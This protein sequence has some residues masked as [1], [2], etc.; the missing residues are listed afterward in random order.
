MDVPPFTTSSLESSATTC[1]TSY[2]SYHSQDP[3]TYADYYRYRG[4][5]TT[6]QYSSLTSPYYP[7]PYGDPHYHHHF[8]SPY[9]ML[10]MQTQQKELVKPPYSYIALI[11]MAIQSSAEKKLTLSGIY[12]FIMDK[13]P[14][15]RQNKQGWQNSIRHN[16]S[17]N[18]CFLKVPRDDN[19][20]GK[21]SYWS[22]DPDSMNMFENGSYLRRRR[23]FRKKENK[24]EM[25]GVDDRHPSGSEDGEHQG[26]NGSIM[27]SEDVSHGITNEN[28]PHSN[29]D[30]TISHGIRS[31]EAQ[32]DAREKENNSPKEQF[33]NSPKHEEFLEKNT[34]EN[35]TK[36][37]TPNMNKQVTTESIKN[38]DTNGETESHTSSEVKEGK[39]EN[40]YEA[41]SSENFTTVSS[42]ETIT[43]TTYQDHTPLSYTN[44][45]SSFLQYH[46]NYSFPDSSTNALVSRYSTERTL[47]STTPS[48]D[49]IVRAAAGSGEGNL[50]AGLAPVTRSEHTSGSAASRLSELA[51]ASNE[52]YNGGATT[53][54]RFMSPP[55]SPFPSSE[56][57][58][59]F[60]TNMNPAY[61]NFANVTGEQE[62]A[63]SFYQPYR[64]AT[65]YPY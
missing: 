21:G 59:D 8:Y 12:Q 7:A 11:S 37:R 38:E 29:N 43:S 30:E 55:N 53:Q 19:K 39:V 4:G 14:Y 64:P 18:E 34:N 44:L 5:V 3:Q 13:F 36:Q 26:W 2:Y 45:D 10:N 41:V 49:Y 20:P 15:Y 42:N 25:E 48:L 6:S 61:Q 17:L 33:K 40:P 65:S 1:P 57:R 9:P 27:S 23:R 31:T 51:S 35:D 32:V 54:V 58:A 16:L 28:I 47:A 52:L 56:A 50:A 46:L 24:K 63:S 62:R 60:Y 22:L